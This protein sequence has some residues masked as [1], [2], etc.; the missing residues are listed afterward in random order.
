[1]I[2]RFVFQSV[3]GILFG[4]FLAVISVMNVVLIGDVNQVEGSVFVTNAL[5]LMFCGWFF[6][7]T[8]LVFEIRSLSLSMQTLVHFMIVTLLYFLLS[9]GIGWIQF[10]L[11]SVLAGVGIF[12]LIYVLIWTGFYF[13]F[14]K[15][16]RKLNEE[17]KQL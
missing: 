2:K 7:V 15:E 16:A 9:F 14:K 1:M 4:A 10:D 6:A 13:Y 17:L 3:V 12:I 11:M 5:G 8:P